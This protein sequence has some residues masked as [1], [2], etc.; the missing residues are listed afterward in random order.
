MN[1]QFSEI[2][3]F[4]DSKTK[5][6]SILDNLVIL[7]AIFFNFLV[8]L[9]C[10]LKS[11]LTNLWDGIDRAVGKLRSRANQHHCI[12]SYH[13]SHLRHVHFHRY[14]TKLIFYDTNYQIT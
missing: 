11:E 5:K 1:E 4:K 7:Y 3:R 9:L 12:P 14:L 10:N 8:K 6:T 13:L 2:R